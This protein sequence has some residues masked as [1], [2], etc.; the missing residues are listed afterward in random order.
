MIQ[1]ENEIPSNR[2]SLGIQKC[3]GASLLTSKKLVL[4]SLEKVS[5]AKPKVDASAWIED[6]LYV[7][8]FIVNPDNV[9]LQL[10]LVTQQQ[11]KSHVI[12]ACIHA[13]P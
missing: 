9:L 5:Q 7:T 10:D 4:H 6:I 11:G 2:E 1:L 13:Q 12:S 8:E 3:F